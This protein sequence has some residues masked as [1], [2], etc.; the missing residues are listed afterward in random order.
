MLSF[1][2]VDIINERVN[3]DEKLG[4]VLVTCLSNFKDEVRSSFLKNV[5]EWFVRKVAF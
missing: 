3:I 2:E 5:L 4:S 1:V